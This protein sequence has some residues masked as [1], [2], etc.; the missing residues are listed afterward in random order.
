MNCN[1][2]LL[3]NKFYENNISMIKKEKACIT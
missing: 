3:Y 1:V 2:I